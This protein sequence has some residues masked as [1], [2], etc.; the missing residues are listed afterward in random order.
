[1]GRSKKRV[2]QSDLI[3]R[4][5]NRYKTSWEEK[6]EQKSTVRLTMALNKKLHELF[7][8]LSYKEIIERMNRFFADESNWLN[9]KAHPIHVFLATS[10][11]YIAKRNG[12]K[13]G[14]KIQGKKFDVKSELGKC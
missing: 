1:M 10:D 12:G 7:S 5:Y 3:F 4:F 6:Y 8:D 9:D 13:N 14:K 2:K 11:N